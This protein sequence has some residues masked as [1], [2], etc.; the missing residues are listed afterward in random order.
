MCE[1]VI[2][3]WRLSGPKPLNNGAWGIDGR[4]LEEPGEYNSGIWLFA[5]R[6]NITHFF[7]PNF[8]PPYDTPEKKELILDV[9]REEWDEQTLSWNPAG[10]K[11]KKITQKQESNNSNNPVAFAAAKAAASLEPRMC[12]FNS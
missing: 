1:A 11:E 5:D 8:L 4:P 2:K 6:E 10:Y 12:G 9:L 3:K 7:P